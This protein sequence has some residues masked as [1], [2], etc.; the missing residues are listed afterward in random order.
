MIMFECRKTDKNLCYPD[1]M[2]GYSKK[3]EQA[4]ALPNALEPLGIP[5]CLAPPSPSS[6]LTTLGVVAEATATLGFREL[7]SVK[8]ST[9]DFIFAL[10]MN[11]NLPQLLYFSFT[12]HSV[13]WPASQGQ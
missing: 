12:L 11:W 7:H 1:S 5:R 13:L 10:E 3:K 9:R 2:V 6:T 4:G 8:P